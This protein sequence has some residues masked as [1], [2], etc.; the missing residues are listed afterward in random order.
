MLLC[1][2]LLFFAKVCMNLYRGYNIHCLFC[3]MNL[4]FSFFFLFF[5]NF[6]IKNL[7]FLDD[8]FLLLLGQVMMSF[9]NRINLYFLIGAQLYHEILYY[10]CIHLIRR[11]HALNLFEV[12]NALWA[13][14]LGFS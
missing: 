11:K 13:E 6:L 9:Y 3:I 1:L 8:F 2:S 7:L 4:Y 12:C 10:N 14:I 5:V